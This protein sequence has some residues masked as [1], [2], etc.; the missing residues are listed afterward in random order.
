M[1]AHVSQTFDHRNTDVVTAA[2]ADQDMHQSGRGETQTSVSGQTTRQGWSYPIAGHA[3]VLSLADGRDAEDHRGSGPAHGAGCYH[4][5]ISADHGY[6][7]S[8]R[9]LGSG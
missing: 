6:V 2:G 9:L 4:H 8:D 3:Q 7:T 5:V 1:S